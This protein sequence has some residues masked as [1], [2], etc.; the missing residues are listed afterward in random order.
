MALRC[1]PLSLCH[2]LI[3]LSNLQRFS[4]LNTGLR[5]KETTNEAYRHVEQ[6]RGVPN[7]RPNLTQAQLAAGI[8]D[9]TAPG[10][11]ADLP[12]LG[13]LHQHCIFSWNLN[14]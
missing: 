8:G 3:R 10:Q 13:H 5:A 7:S 4:G 9:P 6:A 1:E 2:A 14:F 11:E 12:A